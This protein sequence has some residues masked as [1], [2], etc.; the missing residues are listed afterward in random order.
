MR[1][2][3]RQKGGSAGGGED[4][5]KHRGMDAGEED[6]GHWRK[7]EPGTQAVYAWDRPLQ[8]ERRLE[9]K[10]AGDGAPPVSDQNDCAPLHA[11]LRTTTQNWPFSVLVGF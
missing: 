5:G 6:S 7:L 4:N 11:N 9:L 10:F 2:H 3:Y 1:V 8:Q